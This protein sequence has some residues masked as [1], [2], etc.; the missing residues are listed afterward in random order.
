MFLFGLPTVLPAGL[1]FILSM[2]TGF[3]AMLVYIVAGDQDAMFEDLSPRG[4]HTFAMGLMGMAIIASPALF[5]RLQA[6]W[7]DTIARI[8]LLAVLALVPL[9]A[10]RNRSLALALF[11]AS[12][13][14]VTFV[15]WA[16]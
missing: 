16:G 4:D 8:Q 1:H 12:A 3:F 6:P 15:G 9:A 7:W 13:A 5:E 14:W 2:A 10:D 11:G